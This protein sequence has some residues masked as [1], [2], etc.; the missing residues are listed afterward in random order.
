MLYC[1]FILS[2]LITSTMA[3]QHNHDHSHAH[4]AHSHD[5]AHGA[6]HHHHHHGEPLVSKMGE[7]NAAHYE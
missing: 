7:A 6:H 3:C 4:G 2:S 1:F 5:H